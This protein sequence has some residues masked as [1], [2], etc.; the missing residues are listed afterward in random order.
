MSRD[1]ST[2]FGSGYLQDLAIYGGDLSA[3]TVEEHFDANGTDPRPKAAFT[4]SPSPARPGQTVTFNA[5]ESSY[6]KGSIVKYEW[7]LKGTGTYETT[8]T[9][10]TVT[11]SYA[12]EGT[13]KV[14]LRVTDSNGGW[15][16]TT[17][18]VKVGNFP[19]VAHVTVAPSAPL[20]GQ[21]VTLNAS[22]STDQG[23]IT[24]YRWDLEGKGEYTTDTGT[25][26]TVSTYF[27]TAGIHNVGLQLTD[28][29]GL[30]SKTTIPV[31]VLE[32]GAERLHAR[33][34]EHARTDPLLQARRAGGTDGPR[35]R[36]RRATARSAAA[37]SG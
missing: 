36:R 22:G 14:G 29:E 27:H 20:T 7:D 18:E 30:V 28:N 19:P 10:P 15:S 9:T 21:K 12:S 33:G 24:D 3:A 23:T 11:T 13:V 2:L 6:S 16:Y 32:Q 1:A 8:T 25:T 31:K 34:A 37:R 26:P 4:A 17:Q 5:S 35:Q